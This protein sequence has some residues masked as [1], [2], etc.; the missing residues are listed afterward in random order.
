[1]GRA[2][3]RGG[4]RLLR[5]AYAIEPEH[6]GASTARPLPHAGR[7]RPRGGRLGMLAVGQRIYEFYGA[8]PEPGAVGPY[9][10]TMDLELLE[11]TLADAGEPAFRARQVWEWA[12]RGAA[13][14]RR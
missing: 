4:A 3:P 6:G 5:G 12:A 10:E 7:P 8:T 11:R 9:D 13:A 1:M 2:R 14:T